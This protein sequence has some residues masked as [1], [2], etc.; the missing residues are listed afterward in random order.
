MSGRGSPKE[1]GVSVLRRDRKAG[2]GQLFTGRHAPSSD[3]K[4][5]K[6]HVG[7]SAH[8][9]AE[10]CFLKYRRMWPV[11]VCVLTCV[12]CVRECTLWPE[13]PQ[14]CVGRE[15]GRMTRL[16]PG[17]R[18]STVRETTSAG[19]WHSTREGPS[20]GQAF[21]AARPAHQGRPPFYGGDRQPLGH[22]CTDGQRRAACSV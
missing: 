10:R 15:E 2:G 11:G 21:P 9:Q 7:L 13:R 1:A 14:R 8:T 20:Q 4:H 19:G 18:A 12:P 17:E 16:V 6:A 22:K 5:C 3:T